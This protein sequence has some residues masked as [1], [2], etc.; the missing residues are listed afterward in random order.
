MNLFGRCQKI[1]IVKNNLPLIRVKTVAYGS[2][3][4]SLLAQ[5]SYFL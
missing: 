1:K 2:L 5:M 3:S 4:L